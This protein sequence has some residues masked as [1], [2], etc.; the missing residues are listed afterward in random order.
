MK[1]KLRRQ[2]KDYFQIGNYIY[3]DYKGRVAVVIPKGERLTD[4]KIAKDINTLITFYG[5][6]IANNFIKCCSEYLDH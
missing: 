3:A 2:L 1:K 5:V 6:D 4:E